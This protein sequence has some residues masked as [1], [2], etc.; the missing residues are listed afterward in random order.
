MVSGR[1]RA[2]RPRAGRIG[3]GGLLVEQRPAVLLVGTYHG[4]AGQYTTIQAAVDAA[5]PGDWILVA[6]GDYHETDDAHV[7]SASHSC[8]P[9]TTAAWSCTPRTC[10]SGA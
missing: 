9:V 6:P 2:G 3:A 10:T 1:S 7:T 5:Q 4:K 8:R